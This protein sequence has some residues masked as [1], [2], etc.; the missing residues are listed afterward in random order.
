MKRLLVFIVALSIASTATAGLPFISMGVKAGLTS[1]TPRATV[2]NITL[3][4]NA[5][6]GFHAGLVLRAD[7]PLLPIYVQP[8]LLYNWNKYKDQTNTIGDVKLNSFNIPVM[9][10][11]GFGS[12]KIVKIRAN[13]GPVFNL[14]SNVTLANTNSEALRQAFRRPSVTWSAG[15]GVDLIGIM[16]DLRYNFQG[17]KNREDDGTHII[18]YKPQSWSLSLGYLF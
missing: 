12:S 1:E 15:V 11:A 6:T 17:S 2:D 8:E 9:I 16:V 10:G 13:A 4:S 18:T 14:A 7:I 3:T 5:S